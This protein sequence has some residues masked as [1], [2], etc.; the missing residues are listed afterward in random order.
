MGVYMIA[1]SIRPVSVLPLGAIGDEIG[2]PVVLMGA[3]AIV[4]AF[5]ALVAACYPGYRKIGG[6]ASA[7]VPE[8]TV[9]DG[10]PS[11][12]SSGVAPPARHERPAFG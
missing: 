5:V 4:T 6:P 3:G 2:V 7:A 8:E 9:E 12:V 11:G 1:Q 10:A